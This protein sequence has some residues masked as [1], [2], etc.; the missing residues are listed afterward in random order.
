MGN[1]TIVANWLGIGQLLGVDFHRISPDEWIRGCDHELEHWQT[2]DG[3]PKTIAGIA[4]DHLREDPHYYAKLERI[5]NTR[6]AVIEPEVRPLTD[7]EIE[8][9]A[10]VTPEDVRRIRENLVPHVRSLLDA[11]DAK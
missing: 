8:D 5:D 1:K 3:N 7:T 10:K 6:K 4:L 11:R 9:L 2:V